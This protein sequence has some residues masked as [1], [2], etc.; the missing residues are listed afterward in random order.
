MIGPALSCR[1][2]PI[3]A[4]SCPER[5]DSASMM[6]ASGTSARPEASGASPA[7]PS[8]PIV[9]TAGDAQPSVGASMNA[10]VIPD[11]NTSAPA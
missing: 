4:A 2:G 3:R 9:S 10:N 7:T 11:R 6:A 8:N 1:R 5:A